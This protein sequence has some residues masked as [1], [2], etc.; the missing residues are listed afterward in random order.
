MI[1]QFDDVG[2]RALA[3]LE[4]QSFSADFENFDSQLE[5]PAKRAR[6]AVASHRRCLAVVGADSGAAEAQGDQG[7]H[8]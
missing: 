4:A 6:Q 3:F 7:G 5:P 8:I 2:P 1:C